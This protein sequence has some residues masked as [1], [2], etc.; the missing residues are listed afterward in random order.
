MSELAAPF[1]CSNA[2]ERLNCTQP[3]PRLNLAFFV[4]QSPKWTINDYRSPV[5]PNGHWYSR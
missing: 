4:Q 3:L 5:G 2:R 1:L